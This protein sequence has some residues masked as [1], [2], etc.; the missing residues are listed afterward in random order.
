MRTREEIIADLGT[1]TREGVATATE[2]QQLEVLLDI[3]EMLELFCDPEKKKREAEEAGRKA[4]DDL[5]A[6]L[7]P[8]DRARYS[9][10]SVRERAA[11][12]E[13]KK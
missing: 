11:F 6:K 4:R 8:Q 2:Y 10:M 13:T 1:G 7:S 9:K 5:I 12:L 3:R